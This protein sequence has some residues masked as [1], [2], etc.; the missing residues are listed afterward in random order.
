MSF[1]PFDRHSLSGFKKKCRQG[2]S[3]FELKLGL[4]YLE[5]ILQRELNQPRCTHYRGDC[6]KGTSALHI[7]RRWISERGMIEQIKKISPEAQGL[8]L[9]KEEGLAEGKVQ[10]F[11]RRSD[12]AIARNVP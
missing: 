5:R 1:L 10:I 4:P 9:S 11:L 2:N 7:E 8:P 6:G 12:N 3:S